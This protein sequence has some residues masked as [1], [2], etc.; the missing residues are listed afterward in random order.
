MIHKFDLFIINEIL[1][2]NIGIKFFSLIMN[3]LLVLRTLFK[4]F[5]NQITI[6]HQNLLNLNKYL[7]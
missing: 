7:V 1:N 2:L 3:I 4:R 6:I 5:I